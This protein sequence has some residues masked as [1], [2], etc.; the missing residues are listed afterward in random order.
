MKHRRYSP[1][2]NSSETHITVPQIQSRVWLRRYD[3]TQPIVFILPT[4]IGKKR[5]S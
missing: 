1:L 2:F 5:V 4:H 3:V